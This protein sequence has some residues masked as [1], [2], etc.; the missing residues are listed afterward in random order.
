MS[1]IINHSHPTRKKPDQKHPLTAP[2][3]LG[4]L[5]CFSTGIRT[6]EFWINNFFV[7]EYYGEYGIK[8]KELNNLCRDI[9]RGYTPDRFPKKSSTEMDKHDTTS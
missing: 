7:G 3:R 4:L 1:L 2:T 8:I 9:R 6:F 5:E